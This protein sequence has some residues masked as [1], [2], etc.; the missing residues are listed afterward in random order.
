MKRKIIIPHWQTFHTI[1]F[2]FDGF[3]SIIRFIFL[4]MGKKQLDVIDQMD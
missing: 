4:R 2:D 1:I 3:L